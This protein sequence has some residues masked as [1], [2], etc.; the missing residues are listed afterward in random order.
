LAGCA[1]ALLALVLGACGTAGGARTAPTPVEPPIE[2]LA[3]QAAPAEAVSAHE[4]GVA[5]MQGDNLTEAELELE[6]LVLAYPDYPGPYVNLAIVYMREGR[7]E[8]AR[9]ALEEALARDPDHA[10][11]GNQLGIVL[12]R[13]GHFDA[14]EQA[15]LRVIGAHPEY[16]L[17]HLNLGVLLDLYLRRSAEALDCYERYQALRGEPDERVARWIVDLRRRLGAAD[18]AARLAQEDA[19]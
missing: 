18:Q 2:E 5:A 10:A 12:R 19:S 9:A 15:Y 3:A 13:Q 14:A 1:A 8:E 17:A 6:Q 16:A 4:R 7:D 11:A